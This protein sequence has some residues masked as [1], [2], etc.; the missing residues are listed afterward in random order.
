ME[1]YEFMAEKKS[2]QKESPMKSKW[3]E[4]ECCPKCKEVYRLDFMSTRPLV[5]IWNGKIEEWRSST[6]RVKLRCSGCE[7]HF[8]WY[9]ATG[10]ITRAKSQSGRK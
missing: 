4:G 2:H 9:P 3:Q 1:C 5:N 6:N 8:W 7:E 10:K